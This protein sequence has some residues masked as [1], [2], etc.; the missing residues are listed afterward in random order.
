MSMSKLAATLV[1]MNDNRAWTR[2]DELV[3]VQN[4]EN[5]R[6]LRTGRVL[7]ANAVTA[8]TVTRLA[9]PPLRLTEAIWNLDCQAKS[10]HR[11][12]PHCRAVGGDRPA[13]VT[14]KLMERQ[15]QASEF[16]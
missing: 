15:C 8:V 16:Q 2:V 12:G 1:A 13:E 5:A 9:A 6:R 7:S 3:D 10:T 4:L 11:L 14:V